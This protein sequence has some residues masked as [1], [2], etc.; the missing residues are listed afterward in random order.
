MIKTVS[1]RFLEEKGKG[2][3]NFLTNV[4]KIALIKSTLVFDQDTH[5]QWSHVS[6]HEIAGSFGYTTGGET[7]VVDAAWAVDNVNDKAA[8]A[9]TNVTWT[10]SG[11]AFND[12]TQAI[13]YDD[14]HASKVL[15]GCIDFETTISV[16]DGSSFQAQNL[17]YDS[18]GA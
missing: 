10:A 2:A 11:G 6:A 9:W 13:I 8:I 16:T 7:L 15:V 4:F 14:T 3:I 17:G 5:T 12:F 1:Q 18:A